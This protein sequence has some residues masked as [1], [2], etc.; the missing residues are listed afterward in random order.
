MRVLAVGF[1]KK[2]FEN[3]DRLEAIQQTTPVN[4]T[5]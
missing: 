4:M 1:E 5:V 2:R 3:V